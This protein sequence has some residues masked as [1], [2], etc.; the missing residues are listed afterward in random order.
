MILVIFSIWKVSW[1]ANNIIFY[2]FQWLCLNGLNHRDFMKMSEIPLTWQLKPG[3]TIMSISFQSSR[4]L[5]LLISLGPKS[6]QTKIIWLEPSLRVLCSV[7]Q[8]F[9]YCP[10]NIAIHRLYG[11]LNEL[12][13]SPKRRLFF[14]SFNFVFVLPFEINWIYL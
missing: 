12:L 9:F 10:R 8:K 5:I 7:L 3:Q 13:S 4:H 11:N 14:I 1:N 2:L 6:P